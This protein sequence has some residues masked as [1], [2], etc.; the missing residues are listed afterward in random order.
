MT[1]TSPTPSRSKR[2]GTLV[3]GVGLGAT[4]VAAA[5]VASLFPGQVALIWPAAAIAAFAL[6]ERG[7]GMA[8]VIGVAAW[9]SNVWLFGWSLESASAAAAG[10]VLGPLFGLWLLRRRRRPWTGLHDMSDGIWLVLTMGVAGA[11]VAAVSGMLARDLFVEH[12]LRLDVGIHWWVADLSSVVTLVPVADVWRR[13]QTRVHRFDIADLALPAATAIGAFIVYTWPPT[14]SAVPMGLSTLL[15]LPLIWSALRESLRLSVT[16]AAVVGWIAIIATLNHLGP[17]ASLGPGERMLAMQ[18]AA[19]TMS[20]TVLF[21]ALLARERTDALKM[22][23]EVNT[24]L[25]KRVER[26][27]AALRIS[28]TTTLAQLRFQESLL[29]ALPNPVAFSDAQGHFTRVNVAF[30]LLAGKGGPEIHGRTGMQVLGGT[31]GRVW[32]EMDAQLL[33]G[34]REVS[35]EAVWLSPDHDPTV[36][37]LN[38]ALVRD[39]VSR[40]VVGVVTSMQDITALK[41]LQQRL[42]EDEQRF[43]FL[44]EESPVPLVIARA[45]DEVLLFS[46]RAADLLFRGSPDEQ[47]MRSMRALWVDPTQRDQLLLKL[48]R[49]G[50]VRGLEARFRRFDGTEVWLLLSATRGRY[51][52]TDA[53][54]LAF[55]D[56]T[57]AK[58]RETELRTLAYTDVLTG[59]PNRRYFLARAALELR[60]AHR[61]RQP[62]AVLAL[63][64]DHFKQ[65]NDTLGHLVGDGVIRCF[66]STCS[67]QLRGEDVFGRLGGDEFAILLPQT[68]RQVAS[69]VAQRLRLAVQE[70]DCVTAP[71]A[72]QW[73]MTTS[74]GI[75]EYLPTHGEIDIDSLLELADRALYRAKEA[76]RNRVEIWSGAADELV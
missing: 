3:W 28:Q 71:S 30:S 65:I 73:P 55:K 56:I 24:T 49:D 21:A 20:T 76:G 18:I 12:F 58:E 23:R 1:S 7:M 75:A 41:Q 61:Q 37:I 9:A 38:K 74:I 43:R 35:R 29:N 27:T 5:W 47:A 14:D 36:W 66:A 4:Y 25:E 59:I 34:A 33:A 16:M 8:I 63:D 51:R 68:N 60:K 69:E 52:E 45:S 22:L 48:Q 62:L 31:L 15:M 54:I 13:R 70:A 11:T 46:N 64:I 2:S 32:E 53:L 19:I 57:E 39:A 42:A 10:D 40:Q 50:A 44:A 72:S 26:R 67:Q 6:L 17:M